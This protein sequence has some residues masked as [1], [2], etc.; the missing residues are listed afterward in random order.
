MNTIQIALGCAVALANAMSGAAPFAYITNEFGNTVSVIDIAT[1][2]VIGSP[3]DVGVQ[4]TG[5]AAN[6]AGRPYVRRLGLLTSWW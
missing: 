2:A 5:V 4:P 3:I 6:P 1:N